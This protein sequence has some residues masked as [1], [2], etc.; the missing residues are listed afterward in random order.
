[1]LTSLIVPAYAQMLRAL[2]GWLDK[3][4]AQKP[5]AAAEA[6][7]AARLAPDMFPLAVQIRFVCVQAQEPIFR[8]RGEPVPAT[9]DARDAEAFPGTIAEAK[10]QIAAAIAALDAV[11][12]DALDGAA[13][14][15]LA[16][17]MPNGMAFDLTGADYARDWSIPQFYFHLMTA[18]AI[19][20]NNGV[21][22]GKPDYVPHMRSYV[23]QSVPA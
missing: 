12:A 20:R 3:A 19:L 6:L 16:L 18:Y 10:A 2:S 9:L 23:R 8:L 17:A 7:L 14:Q 13:Q 15:P 11:P 21:D 1:M 4:E 22:L 5:G